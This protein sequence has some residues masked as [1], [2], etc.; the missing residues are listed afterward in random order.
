M[1]VFGVT[2]MLALHQEIPED[3]L[4]RVVAYDILGSVSLVPVG[5]ALAG[6]AADAFG[7]SYALLGCAG[8]TVLLTGAVLFVPEV[9]GLT[10]T[11]APR[12]VP[13]PTLNAPSGGSGDGTAAVS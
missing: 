11:K 13:Q 7:V 10:R 5:T 4:S 2:W 1:E 12:A 6:P 8:L 9:R 3:K